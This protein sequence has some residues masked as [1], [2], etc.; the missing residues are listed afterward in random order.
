MVTCKNM[1]EKTKRII[2]LLA[3]ALLIPIGLASAQEVS[4]GEQEPAGP[5]GT[6][7]ENSPEQDNVILRQIEPQE[8]VG[9]HTTD[10]RPI[11]SYLYVKYTYSSD[12]LEHMGIDHVFREEVLPIPDTVSNEDVS[13]FGDDP[14]T[15]QN[16]TLNLIHGDDIS[17]FD[18]ILVDGAE[19]STHMFQQWEIV[20]TERD[21]TQPTNMSY[22]QVSHTEDWAST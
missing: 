12:G 13:R 8:F 19:V 5:V 10:V 4:G 3:L 21:D 18:R 1:G 17:A 7:D 6:V 20:K 2:S 14:V 15:S 9:Q 16:Y 11:C 22:R